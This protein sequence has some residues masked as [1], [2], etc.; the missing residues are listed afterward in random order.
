MG[1]PAKCLG[2]LQATC[3]VGVIYFKNFFLSQENPLTFDWYMILSKSDLRDPLNPFFL[4]QKK[5]AVYLQ[6]KY[7]GHFIKMPN[8]R[9]LNWVLVDLIRPPT[10]VKMF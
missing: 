2:A 8:F 7:F 1:A 4:V 6:K 5:N 3:Q 9:F 10:V